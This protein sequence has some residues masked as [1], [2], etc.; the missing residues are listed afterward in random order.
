[1]EE[2]AENAE[3]LPVP[4]L[5]LLAA[6][7]FVAIMTETV[8]A[9]LLDPIARG[10]AVS[11]AV[12]GQLV[13]AYAAGSVAAAIP[14]MALTARWRRRT[15]LL[16]PAFGLF[17]A[18]GVTAVSHDVT[19]TMAARLVGGISAGLAWALVASY[20]RLLAPPRLQGRAL[21]LAMT[22]TPVALSIGVPLGTF[23]GG[24]V[25]WRATFGLLAAATLLLCGGIRVRL[26][27]FPGRMDGIGA[28]LAA[29]LR[30][31]TLRTV[32]FVVFGWML[33]HNALYTFVAPLAARAGLGL[34]VDLV[35]LL[36]GLAALGGIALAGRVVDRRLR[37][38]TIGSLLLFAAVAAVLSVAGHGA[39][40][41]LA[42]AACWGLSFGGASTFLN[43]AAAEAVP[44]GTDMAVAAVTTVWNTAIAGGGML[45]GALLAR[46]GAGALGPAALLCLL[47]VLL[48][49]LLPAGRRAFAPEARG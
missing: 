19:L 18:N 48:V 49:V 37:G 45:G 25:G 44:E 15:A 20:A 12:A 35:L 4:A 27:D 5:M 30:A 23:L 28:A 43:T 33:A 36:F 22:G 17:A 29:A 11:P 41:V 42:C 26:P 14:L 32:L 13:T 6:T 7:G 9:G 2:D 3:R 10:L 46:I 1:M 21:A 38:A 40:V 34:E 31:R 47:P 24:L 8:P 39:A 16:L